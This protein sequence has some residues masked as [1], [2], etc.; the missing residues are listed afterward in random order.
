MH[1][2]D[3]VGYP[4]GELEQVSGW[5]DPSGRGDEHLTEG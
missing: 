5:E 4:R 3:C 1:Q 2:D